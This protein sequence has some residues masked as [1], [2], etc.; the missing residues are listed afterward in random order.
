MRLTGKALLMVFVILLAAS[1]AGIWLFKVKPITA[2]WNGTVYIHPDGTIDPPNAP[3]ATTDNVIYTL[4]DNI[5]SPGHGIVVEKD[6]IVLDGAGH[7]VSGSNALGTYGVKLTGRSNVTVKNM[8]ISDFYVGIRIYSSLSI[9]VFNCSAVSGHTGVSLFNSSQSNVTY[10]ALTSNLFG[11][12]LSSN[13]DNN[14]IFYNNI[15]GNIQV[16]VLI[17]SECNGNTING[18]NLMDN[19]Q[20]SVKIIGSSPHNRF[21]HNVFGNPVE[22]TTNAL[23]YWDNGYPGGGNY[24]SNYTG[25]DLKSGPYQNET[26]S[27]GIGDTA[28]TINGSNVDQYPFIAPVTVFDAGVWDGTYYTVKVISNSTVGGF[29]FNPAYAEITF[30]VSGQLKSVGFC[31]VIIPK[32]LLWAEPDSWTVHR[33][34]GGNLPY[35]TSTDQD[36]TYL[37]FTYYFNEWISF[38]YIQITGTNVIPEFPTKLALAMLLTVT[39]IIAAIR[40]KK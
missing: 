12:Q 22:I 11:V 10:N 9:S 30:S 28:Y 27:D 20:N 6:D 3:I 13:S 18:N 29:Y 2:A 19:G 34:F 24:W 25:V 26:G 4:M 8:A 16:G 33:M 7:T 32:E 5:T 38:D 23:N 1:I 14:N 35:T 21:Y 31:R 40:N 17:Y 36:N 39:I 37:Y 15:T